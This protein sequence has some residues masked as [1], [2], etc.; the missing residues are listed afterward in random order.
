MQ[1]I[2]TQVA[3]FRC[4]VKKFEN[5]VNQHIQDGWHLEGYSIEKKGLRFLCHAK[6]AICHESYQKLVEANDSDEVE[7][8]WWYDWFG[9]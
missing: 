2:I 5:E 9:Y 3:I 8:S 1:K 4:G 7:S 6:F